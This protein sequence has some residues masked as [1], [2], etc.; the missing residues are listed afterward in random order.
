MVVQMTN[1]LLAVVMA[2]A[3]SS[4]LVAHAAQNTRTQLPAL[5][6]LQLP[7]VPRV[8]LPA[9]SPLPTALRAVAGSAL[10]PDRAAIKAAYQRDHD[11]LEHLRQQASDLR[12]P[13]HPAFNHLVQQDEQALLEMEEAALSA[14]LTAEGLSTVVTNMDSVVNQARNDLA[15]A[16]AQD[17][18][19]KTNNARGSSSHND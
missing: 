2:L 11:A 15:V 13:A 6:H 9:V 8:S 16:R 18:A 12:G 1:R 7:A 3:F 4:G 19:L 5:P 17:N 10:E 14:Q